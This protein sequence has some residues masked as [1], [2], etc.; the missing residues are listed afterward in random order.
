ML[1]ENRLEQTT[2]LYQFLLIAGIIIISFNLRPAIT[3]VGPL[4]GIIRDDLSLS[5]GITGLITSLP[6]VA[7][8]IMSPFA[9]RIGNRFS[10]E[11]AMIIGLILLLFGISIRSI[12]FV[13]L[14]FTGTFIA[15]SGIAI[16][17]VLLPGIIKDKFPNKVGLM[18]SIYT[19]TMGIISAVA[20][21][22]SI[23]IA[24]NLNLGWQIALLV[25]GIPAALGIV[26][27][28]YLKLKSPRRE[29]EYEK[30]VKY[31]H[32]TEKKIWRVPLAWQIAAFMGFQSFL[33]Y[34]TMSWLPEIL[35]SNG[36]SMELAGWILSYTLFVGL[37][38][39]FTV[40]VVA[41]KVKSLHGIV[42]FLTLSL[43]FGYLGILLS[44]HIVIIIISTTLIGI[45]LSG[46]F[47]LALTLLGLRART[48]K[49]AAELSGMAQSVG[50]VLA[51]IGPIFIGWLFD[52]TGSWNVPIIAIMVFILLILVFGL[53]VSKE[54]YVYE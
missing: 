16:L 23:P 20:S 37:P 46:V 13:T 6:L 40:P 33:F 38:A 7:F 45:A 28:A 43:F 24:V 39:S 11:G 34:V 3:S 12:S 18:T 44:S 52:I 27:W 10:Y 14:L 2:K 48:A 31:V 29:H 26:V 36:M 1:N 5:N 35:Y 49:D 15:G 4:I 51:A 54:R 19:T 32:A 53:M 21:G 22:V 9:A 50:Y 25:W 47:A 42:L 17:N 8:A 30:T 41:E